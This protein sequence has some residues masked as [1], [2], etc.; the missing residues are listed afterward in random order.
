MTHLNLS[1]RF[2]SKFL[3]A[4][5]LLVSSTIAIAPAHAESIKNVTIGGT[6]ASDYILYDSN[7]TN[8]FANPNANLQTLIGGTAANPTGNV[9]LAASSEK[10]GFDFTKNT[11][12]NGTIGGRSISISSLTESDWASS[13]EKYGKKTFGQYWFDSALTAYGLSSM[14]GTTVGTNFFNAFKNNGGFQRFSDPNISYVSQDANNVINIGLAGHYD[15]SS[16]FTKSI[17]Q[18]LLA[19]PA[20]SNTQKLGMMALKNQLSKPP[21]TAKPTL[22]LASLQ[23][24]LA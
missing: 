2:N 16:L 14:V 15:A 11:S 13:S 20:L 5:S 24:T 9:E 18:Y 19:N 12:L 6:A 22:A 3:I 17:D 4:A 23:R 8:T 21:T 1:T 10:A 7:A